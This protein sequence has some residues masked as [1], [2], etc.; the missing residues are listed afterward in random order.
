MTAGSVVFLFILVAAMGF[1]AL[2]VQRL[3]SYLRLGYADNRLDHPLTRIKNVLVIGIAQKK[4]LR[5]PIAGPMH[6]L[7][8]WGFMVL[9]A[10]TI[11]ILI[12]G[13][14]PAFSYAMLLPKPLYNAYAASQDV[15]AVLVIAA[16][17]F[18][19]YRRI[20]LH[21]KR[22]EGDDLE[23]TDAIIILS[24]IGGLMLTLLMSNGFLLAANHQ[25]FGSEK[26]VSK[27]L[28]ILINHMMGPRAA[29]ARY[30]VF[31]WA[32]ALLILTFLNYLPYSKHLHVAS[33]LINVYFSNTSGP[34]IKGAMRYMD[35]ETEAESFGASDVDQLSWKNL[36]D[37]FSCTECGRCTAAC[38]ANITGKPLSPRK[39][40]VNTRQRLME[41]APVVTS[42][43]MDFMRSALLHGEF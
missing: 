24:M 15:F 19:L 11:E 18:A 33:S 31:W 38:P 7:I 32:H 5:D 26:V 28:G 4:I 9:T 13:V 30:H 25:A 3:A 12:E 17:G 29:M 36:L 6:A 8:F 20:V 42:D 41:K 2:N 23:H 37:G 40:I 14:W 27:P 22:L 43:R 10:G 34:G 35:L 21:P 1:F 16:V 39:I